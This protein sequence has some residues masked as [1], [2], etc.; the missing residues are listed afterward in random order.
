MRRAGGLLGAAVAIAVLVPWHGADPSSLDEDWSIPAETGLV[1]P[2][3][4]LWPS[5]GPQFTGDAV[6]V[7]CHHR[8]EEALQ[9]SHH[10]QGTITLAL[11]EVALSIAGRLGIEAPE[12]STL[13][14]SCHLATAGGDDAAERHVTGGV[15]CESC[16]GTG[17]GFAD[18]HWRYGDGKMIAIQETP[19][20]KV[21]R[22]E[23]STAAGM[24]RGDNVHRMAQACLSCH[25]IADQTLVDVGGHPVSRGF[26]VI[27]WSQGEVRHN[28]LFNRGKENP[29]AG[30]E[31]QRLMLVLGTL[32]RLEANL[33]ALAR[34]TGDGPHAAV[35]A[36]EARDAAAL[37]A[38]IASLSEDTALLS[39]MPVL[40]TARLQL[41]DP[42]AM[43]ALAQRVAAAAADVTARRDGSGLAML[44]PL[45][46]APQDYVGDV[47]E[48]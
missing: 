33:L 42:A 40:E 18:I 44:D 17:R 30:P 16:H 5:P 12:R 29:P 19:E 9:A 37:T 36:A 31:R 24:I 15:G 46:P 20:H 38:T 4:L 26:D 25:V 35:L 43:T 47:L 10:S 28:T 23:Q 13:C 11:S 39:L 21:E 27:A 32:A 14:I 3:G 41:G 6:C 7:R 48:P 22:L 45:L 34:A 8:A 2:T 1:E